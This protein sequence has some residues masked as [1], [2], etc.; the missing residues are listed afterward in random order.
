MRIKVELSPQR[1]SLR[2]VLSL[3]LSKDEDFEFGQALE[4]EDS[5]AIFKDAGVGKYDL[6]DGTGVDIDPSHHHHIVTP[7]KN[8][9]IKTRICLATATNLITRGLNQ[10]SSPIANQG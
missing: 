9:P 10:I 3:G 6:I 2:S 4:G 8:T 1:T 5:H 7:P